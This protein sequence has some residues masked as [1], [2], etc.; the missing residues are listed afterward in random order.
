MKRTPNIAMALIALAVIAASIHSHRTA[1]AT[2]QPQIK[3]TPKPE[4]TLRWLSTV[5][6]NKTT[7][8]GGSVDGDIT[9]TVHLLRPA[10]S[11]LTITLSTEGCLLDEAG[12]LVA[13]LPLTVITI[14]AGSDRATFRIQTL[15]S[16]NTPSA[17]TCTV[18]AHYGD[19]HVAAN[20]TVE[21]LRTIS[22]DIVPGAGIGPFTATGT[23]ALNARPAANKTV[24]LTRSNSI[25]RFGTIGNAQPDASVTFTSTS[26]QRTVSVVASAVTQPTTVTITAKLGAQTLIRQITVRPVI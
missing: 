24:T 9:G 22:F 15:S 19:E 18:R 25:V 10:L 26:S 17:I 2:P 13:T 16:P 5:T 6:L 1:A 14:P 3:P 4:L 7:T 8:V 23:I 11:D 20:F 12:I 21:P